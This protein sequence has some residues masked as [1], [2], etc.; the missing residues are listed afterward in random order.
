M[1]TSQT[2]GVLLAIS[3]VILASCEPMRVN[4][5]PIGMYPTG[6]VYPGNP[7]MQ[8][9]EYMQQGNSLLDDVRGGTTPNPL[10]PGSAF[11]PDPGNTGGGTI[12]NLIG[13]DTGNNNPG[14]NPG[15]QNNGI[16]APRPVAPAVN[17]DIPVA[18]RT[19]DPTVVISPYDRT[20]KVKILNRKTNQPYP[21]GTVLRDT[22]Y[23]NEVR[24]FRVP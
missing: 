7:N 4:E 11:N 24:K 18:I 5:H 15:I 3:A 19:A 16:A 13:G 8:N 17:S 6:N 21:S 1:K 14:I 2:I 20:K 23:P 12:R 22:N 10:N 9:S